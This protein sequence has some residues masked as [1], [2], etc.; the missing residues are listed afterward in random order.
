MKS[1]DNKSGT[2]VAHIALVVVAIVAMVTGGAVAAAGMFNTSS[3]GN[4]NLGTLTPGQTGNA[5]ATT[6]VHVSNTTRYIFQL[7]KEDRIGS[8]FSYFAVHVSVNGQT[9]NLT[10]ERNDSQ[11]NLSSGTYTFTLQLSY[12]VRDLVQN[13]SESNVAFLFLHPVT[14][15][16]NENDTDSSHN[17]TTDGSIQV[18]SADNSGTNNQSNANRLALFTLTFLVHGNIGDNN[19]AD[20]SDT[21]RSYAVLSEK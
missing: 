1:Y 12:A 15:E 5:T 16:M 6:T 8:T 19:E 20:I 17:G 21:A 14:N 13:V 3:A 11:I 2:M 18:V 9:L 4:L 7:E 10:G